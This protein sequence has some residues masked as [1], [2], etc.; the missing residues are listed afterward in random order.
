MRPDPTTMVESY[1][2]PIEQV[3]A[4]SE[5][6]RVGRV[7]AEESRYPVPGYYSTAMT[8][9]HHAYPMVDMIHSPQAPSSGEYAYHMGYM[10]RALPLQIP[11]GTPAIYAMAPHP[12]NYDASWGNLQNPL[13]HQPDTGYIGDQ[14]MLYPGPGLHQSA[15]LN[16]YGLRGH[17]FRPDHESRSRQE[18]PGFGGSLKQSR[19]SVAWL[20]RW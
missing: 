4:D 11:L 6:Q 12:Y 10:W 9:G 3:T 19:K 16:P 2:R 17:D 5:P 8:F 18:A 13:Q 1:D 20:T 15:H 14:S 7:A